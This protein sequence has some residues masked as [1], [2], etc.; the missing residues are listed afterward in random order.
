VSTRV[1]N[2]VERFTLVGDDKSF[3][4]T[5]KGAAK[6]TQ[7]LDHNMSKLGKV[8][9]AFGVSGIGRGFGDLKQALG[10]FARGNLSYGVSSLSRAFT[11]LNAAGRGAYAAIGMASA[12]VA[13]IVAVG[14][15]ATKTYMALGRTLQ[16]FSRIGGL[17]PDTSLQLYG[18]LKMTGA[19]VGLASK[20]LGMFAKNLKVAQGGTGNQAKAMAMLDIELRKSNGDWKSVS[21]ILPEYRNALSGTKDAATKAF[22]AQSMLGRGYQSLSKW[23]SVS[24]KDI[25]R[26]N[27]IVAATGFTWLGKDSGGMKK[28]LETQRQIS[29]TWEL[30]LAG[31]GK[32]ISPYIAKIMKAAAVIGPAFLNGF[33]AGAKAIA[34][35][36]APLGWVVKALDKLF[37]SLDVVKKLAS[38]FG[39]L[40]PI[41]IAIGGALTTFVLA[42]K[43]LQALS[44]AKA[45]AAAWY[46]EKVAIDANTASAVANARAKETGVLPPNIYGRG[47]AG[48]MGTALPDYAGKARIAQQA[49]IAERETAQAAKLAKMA[50]AASAAGIAPALVPA[51]RAVDELGVAA[52]ATGGRFAAMGA[53]IKAAAVSSIVAMGPWIIAAAAVGAA[54]MGIKWAYGQWQDAEKQAAA[55][56]ANFAATIGK[57]LAGVQQKIGIVS[58]KYRDFANL[59]ATDVASDLNDHIEAGKKSFLGGPVWFHGTGDAERVAAESA[60]KILDTTQ[61]IFDQGPMTEA[62]KAKVVDAIKTL[63]GLGTIAAPAVALLSGELLAID[64]SALDT[65][66]QKAAKL[67]QVLKDNATLISVLIPGMSGPATMSQA[68][69]KSAGWMDKAGGMLKGATIVDPATLVD[70]AAI[71]QAASDA[72]NTAASTLVGMATT[73]AG[74]AKNIV[75]KINK[76]DWRAVGVA[77]RKAT[78][79]MMK[80]WGDVGGTGGSGLASTLLDLPNALLSLATSLAAVPKNIVA[81]INE[82]DWFAAGVAI[83]KAEDA[84]VAGAGMGSASSALSVTVAPTYS[85]RFKPGQKGMKYASGADFITKG[86]TPM[87]VGEA[88][89]EHVRVTPLTG[90]HARPAAPVVHVHIGTVVGT[91]E[92][93]ARKLSEMVGRHLSRGVMRQMVG[94]NA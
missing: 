65:A 27:K 50:E 16:Q 15:K 19:D 81:K 60:K 20:N 70:P 13:G 55:A 8:F 31:I 12:A 63:Q 18:Q 58:Q 3:G 22:A 43:G 44:G 9:Q 28:L 56:H 74:I 54:Y 11:G 66:A 85:G 39:F 48:A 92:A 75:K 46:A 35:I 73:F 94:Q 78:D 25:K 79:A 86:A 91:D 71:Q 49:R 84:L 77:I 41:I 1:N 6:D 47:G 82:K 83:R 68:N 34:V 62:G 26:Y 53:S 61:K 32:A 90:P 93:A 72:R 59:L 88:G 33:K 51:T 14:I 17:K 67:A 69:A 87:I 21:E 57:D 42:V 23:I 37:P 30:M 40:L 7:N 36:F 52:S 76:Q 10:G 5:F 38:A 64:P 45:A 29:L 89:P 80:G 2:V 4:K 24:E